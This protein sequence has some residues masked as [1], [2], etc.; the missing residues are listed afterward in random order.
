[1]HRADGE[2]AFDFDRHAGGIDHVLKLHRG[3]VTRVP[4]AAG[5]GRLRL[6]GAERK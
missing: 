5:G 6:G 1:M 2:I 4:H 3:A